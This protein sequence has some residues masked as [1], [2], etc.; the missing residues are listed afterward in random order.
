[1]SR[2]DTLIDLMRTIAPQ[3]P[4]DAWRSLTTNQN[5]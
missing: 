2:G 4:E 3:R 5:G 1:M